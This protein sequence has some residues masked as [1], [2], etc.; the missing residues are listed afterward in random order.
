MPVHV[1]PEEIAR[2]RTLGGALDLCAKAAG[3]A[4]DKELQIA[5]GVDKAQFSRW[6][7]GAEGIHGDKTLWR[8]RK[9][10]ELGAL[11]IT[12]SRLAQAR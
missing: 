7:S 1:S 9:L 8:I 10:D 5:L 2:E 4:L 3:Y 6:H 12:L 11:N